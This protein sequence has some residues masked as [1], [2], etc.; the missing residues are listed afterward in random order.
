M[1]GLYCRPKYYCIIPSKWTVG[2]YTFSTIFNSKSKAVHIRSPIKRLMAVM[3][4]F[5]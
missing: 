3:S 4:F 2:V 1:N 5:P